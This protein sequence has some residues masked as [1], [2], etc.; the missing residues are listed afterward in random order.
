MGLQHA[1]AFIYD[2]EEPG[3]ARLELDLVDGFRCHT[4]VKQIGLRRLEL[5]AT[6]FVRVRGG[7]IPRLVRDAVEKYNHGLRQA[8]KIATR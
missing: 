8:P 1:E 6:Q 3:R 2:G 5:D 7:D 4:I